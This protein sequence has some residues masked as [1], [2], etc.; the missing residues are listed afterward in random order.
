MPKPRLRSP[1]DALA[2]LMVNT[3]ARPY[4]RYPQSASDMQTCVLAL[5]SKFEFMPRFAPLTL[6]DM[7]WTAGSDSP[8]APEPPPPPQPRPSDLRTAPHLLAAMRLGLNE[9]R[10][11][12]NYPESHSDMLGC[13]FAVLAGFDVQ[14]RAVPFRLEDMAWPALDADAVDT[15]DHAPSPAPRARRLIDSVLITNWTATSATR[16]IHNLAVSPCAHVDDAALAHE[17]LRWLR[18]AT[19][20]DPDELARALEDLRPTGAD[21]S[22]WDALRE[23]LCNDSIDE[24]L[25]W[26]REHY[27]DPVGVLCAL[28][29]E[30]VEPG[31]DWD[32]LG[33]EYRRAVE[34]LLT[35]GTPEAL[36]FLLGHVGLVC[37]RPHALFAH[38][39][40]PKREELG[41]AALGAWH[42]LPWID[43]G[44][45]VLWLAERDLPITGL[46]ELLLSV[47]G[48]ALGFSDRIEYVHALSFTGGQPAT[49]RM[50]QLLD[51]ALDMTNATD[52]WKGFVVETMACLGPA[53]L[54]PEQCLR[55]EQG[56]IPRKAWMRAVH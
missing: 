20:R 7:A 16:A 8:V 31:E 44:T 37:W 13:V 41:R 36:R 5:L 22:S 4:R 55:A 53:E 26:L 42:A 49:M 6:A 43:R 40:E 21:A 10:P 28:L 33:H 17:L 54:T 50:H 38:L 15:A 30:G 14:P 39:I 29:H 51:R 25:A 52:D 35:L 1:F 56:G 12:L 18:C 11:D 48:E 9:W 24:T 3:M 23:G 45:L 46:V 27:P 34:V 2:T 47:E 19:T 32:G